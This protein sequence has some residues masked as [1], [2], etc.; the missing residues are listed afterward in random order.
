MSILKREIESIGAIVLAAGM[1]T[2]MKQPKLIMPWGNQ[3][4]IS[5][6][7]RVLNAAGIQTIRVVLGG[8][9]TQ[10]SNVLTGLSVDFVV[11][12]HFANGEMIESL[13]VGL[14]D[15]PLTIQAILMVLGD[16]PQIQ[17]AT[18]RNL[19]EQYHRSYSPLIIP[20]YQFRRGHP[21]LIHRNL[22][23]EIQEIV[24]P[25]TLRDFLNNHENEIEYLP[26]DDPTI[27]QDLDTIEDYQKFYPDSLNP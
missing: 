21:W 11:N 9:E 14:I 10:L 5:H 7:I 24:P 23:N 2:R 22:W 4:V 16:Q 6:V 8:Y 25:K 20:S 19:V 18:V 26:I 1:S 12:P 27:L 3:T 15:M 17:E 13:K